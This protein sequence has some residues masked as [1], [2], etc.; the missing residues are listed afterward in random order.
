LA[1]Q[2]LGRIEDAEAEFR[3][4]VTLRPT[5]AMAHNNLGQLLCARNDRAGASEHFR[6][7]LELDPSIAEA[8]CNLGQILLEQGEI[9]VALRHSREAVRLRPTLA[10]AHIN[11]GNVLRAK[12]QLT[13]ARAAYAEALR[14]QPDQG[15][16]L[17]NMGQALQEEGK[18][19]DAVTWYRQALAL[20]PQSSRVHA[21]LASALEEQE[22]FDEAAAVYETAVNLDPENAAVHNH[23]GFVRRELGQ[24]EPALASYHEALR[25]QPDFP[26]ALQNLGLLLEELGRL[27][28]A[29]AAIRKAITLQPSFAGGHSALATLLRNRLPDADFVA[30]RQLL[31]SL[32]LHEEGRA[33]LHFGAAQ[34]LDGRNDFAG[35]SEHL[36]RGN[37]L[38]LELLRRRSRDYSPAAHTRQIDRLMAA[39]TPEFFERVRDFGVESERPVFIVGLPRSGTTLLEQVLASHT[40]VH[41]AGELGVMMKNLARLPLDLGCDLPLPDCLQ[42]LDQ[43]TV[44]RGAQRYLDYISDLNPHA[45]RVVDKMP[46]NYLA[47]GLIATLFPRARIIYARRD[48]RDVAVSCW[49][50]NFRHL[51]WSFDPEYIATRLNE[52][53]RIM[54]HWRRVL[55][56]PMLE[57]NYANTVADLEGMARRMVDFCGLEWESA[58]LSFHELQRPV[59]T[60]SVTQVRQPIYKRSVA[61]WKNYEPYLASLFRLLPAAG[62]SNP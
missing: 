35:A 44:Q 47:V 40:H 22:E 58:C 43:A 20:D 39:F 14:L 37:A 54:D 55:P 27:P 30:L 9:D 45:P 28:Q 18:L 10:E 61:R 60:A 53:V 8:H 26:E 52:H 25:L 59:R 24:H 36:C 31:N 15:M 23:L 57:V 13:D 11:L 56:V 2:A 48:L 21:N 4:A 3:S 19:D 12:G 33:A 5:Y 41:G 38:T 29:E 17:N 62:D 34:V 16:A 7:A 49:M 50:T 1:L 46:D 6:R 51:H 42:R 32:Q